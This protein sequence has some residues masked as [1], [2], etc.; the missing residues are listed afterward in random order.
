MHEILAMVKKDLLLLLRDRMGF[1]FTFFFPLVMAI[2]FGALFAGGGS[3]SREMSVAVVD[4]DG[5]EESRALVRKLDEGPELAVTPMARDSAGEAVRL[6]RRMAFIGIPRGFAEARRR[7]F[8]GPAPELE[9]GLDPSRAAEGGMLQGVLSK[10]MAEG[11]QRM[12]S[13]PDSM[14]RQITDGMAALDAARGMSE[15]RREPMRRFLA[16]LDRFLASSAADSMPDLGAGGP[17]DRGGGFEPVRFKTTDIA[18]VRRGPRNAF[19]VSFPQGVLWAILSCSFGFALSLVNERTRGTLVRLRMA[20]VSRRRILIAKGVGCL[21]T[22]LSISTILLLIGAF[23]FRVQPTSVPLLALA[24][25]SAAIGFVGMMMLTSVMGRTEQGVS[26]F[27]WAVMMLMAMT[28]GA[29]IPLFAMP[30]WMQSASAVSPVK[31]AIL[32]VEG[33]IWRDFTLAQMA[34]PCGILVAIGLVGSLVGMRV[35]RWTEA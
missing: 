2:F 5:T 25:L 7:M 28:G 19:Q 17:A 8:Y 32:A 14:R 10:Y 11:M 20:P 31:W 13:Q 26:G 6:G 29:M 33:G 18:R 21:L 35:F 4:E 22:I 9:L 16:E 12:F 27:G 23:V 15:A 1:F 30:A 3:G 24:V 34:L